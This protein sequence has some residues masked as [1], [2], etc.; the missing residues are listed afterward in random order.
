MPSPGSPRPAP[1][2]LIRCWGR[3]LVECAEALD[4]LDETDA[5]QVLGSIDAVK[6]RSS[7]TLFE[8]AAAGGSDA[9][10][11]VFGRVLE[12]YFGGHRDDATLAILGL[13]R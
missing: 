4:A 3:R 5:E 13:H 12:H 1:T 11:G 6:L 10:H 2:S 7:M 9:A 8:A